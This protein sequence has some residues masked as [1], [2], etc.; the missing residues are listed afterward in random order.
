MD[1]TEG[2][3]LQLPFN[4]HPQPQLASG[5][6]QFERLARHLGT[7][8]IRVGRIETQRLGCGWPDATE[9]RGCLPPWP[10]ASCA[11]LRSG[12]AFP[13]DC[14]HRLPDRPQRILYY[15]AQAIETINTLHQMRCRLAKPR[16]YVRDG[17][18][19]RRHG[20][21]Q[22]RNPRFEIKL[23]PGND[24]RHTQGMRPDPLAAPSADG[25]HKPPRH[26]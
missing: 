26:R 15:R 12:P 24:H 13:L 1:E 9:R 20:K 4:P 22:R 2:Q 19:L 14:F 3:I 6:L 16:F 17:T 7:Q 5:E 8:V 21:K 11:T 18:V 10:A 25:R 23:Q